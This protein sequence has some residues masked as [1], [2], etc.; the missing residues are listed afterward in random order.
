MKWVFENYLI[1][2]IYLRVDKENHRARRCYNKIGFSRWG[3]PNLF[4]CSYLMEISKSSS[5]KGI[6]M[7]LGFLLATDLQRA[8]RNYQPRGAVQPGDGVPICS[9]N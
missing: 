6:Q 9:D 3:W 8:N 4:L 5:S 7:N 1:K 2:T